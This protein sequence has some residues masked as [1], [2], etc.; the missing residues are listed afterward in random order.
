MKIGFIFP[1]SEYLHDPFRGD[2]HTHFQILTVLEDR[3]GTERITP[4]LIDLRGIKKKFALN[5]IPECDL[6]LHSVYTL[7]YNEQMASVKGLRERY[8]RAKHIAGGP[9]VNEFQKESLK[10]F[11]SIVLGDGEECIIRAVKDLENKKLKKIYEQQ[12]PINLDDYPFPR[13]HWLPEATIARKNMMNVKTKVEYDEMLGTTVIFSRGCPSNCAFCAMPKFKKYNPKMRFRS[14]K[15]I[16]D[17]IMYLKK[18][19]DIEV[20]SLLDEIGIPPVEKLAIEQL[21]AIKKTGI[22]WRGQC[23]V[24]GVKPEIAELARE[25]GCLAMGLGVESVSQRALNLINKRIQI[26]QAKKTIK[27]LKKNDIEAR[28]YLIMGLPGEPL[29]IT[30]KTWDFIQETEP[31]SIILSLFT[32]RPGTEVFENPK[33]FGIKNITSSWETTMHMWGRYNKEKPTLTFEYEKNAPWGKTL[34]SEEIIDNYLDLQ[35]RVKEHGYGPFRGYKAPDL[36]QLC[37]DMATSG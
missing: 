36:E 32:V 34:S 35:E 13:R 16:Y 10:I 20:I 30:E 28:I 14:P 12:G 19:Y 5:H 25:S 23:R 9:H 18:N 26:D 29:D 27:I 24:D 21:K 2:P 22:A 15:S 33:K 7:D 37:H 3:F 31:D 17:E 11:D 8:P 6:Y 4:M 1:S